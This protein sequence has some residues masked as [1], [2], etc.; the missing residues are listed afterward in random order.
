MCSEG[1]FFNTFAVVMRIAAA[2]P[3]HFSYTVSSHAPECRGA[4]SCR[5][6]TGYCSCSY[7][8]C[9]GKIHLFI[10]RRMVRTGYDQLVVVHTVLVCNPG[11]NLCNFCA[12]SGLL[13]KV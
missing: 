2:G 13:P 1:L 6:Y 5:L 12:V 9:D 8:R 10:D 7:H 3:V 4:W 11:C